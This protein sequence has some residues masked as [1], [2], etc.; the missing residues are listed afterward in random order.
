[1]FFSKKS[2]ICTASRG[3][4]VTLQSVSVVMSAFAETSDRISANVDA[5]SLSFFLVK[6]FRVAGGLLIFE[7]AFKNERLCSIARWRSL[8]SDC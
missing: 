4:S 7:L 3:V 6:P 2:A 1:M 5:L 8:K